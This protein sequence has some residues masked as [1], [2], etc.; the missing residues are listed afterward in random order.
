MS[1][2]TWEIAKGLR[3]YVHTVQHII[4]IFFLMLTVFA[5]TSCKTCFKTGTIQ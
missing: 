1:N 5:L 3:V 4:N 2:S